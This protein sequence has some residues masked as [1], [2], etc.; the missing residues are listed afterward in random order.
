MIIQGQVGPLATSASLAAGTQPNL[1]QG[2]MGD[3]IV[4]ELHGRYYENAY[5]RNQFWAANPTGDTTT[6][7]TST[8][9]LFGLIYGSVSYPCHLVRK[10]R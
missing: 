6:A 5:R 2:N 8:I 9:T 4:S 7:T 3:M 10:W 1:R